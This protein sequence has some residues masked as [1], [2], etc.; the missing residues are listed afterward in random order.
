MS[1]VRKVAAQKAKHR[2]AAIRRMMVLDALRNWLIPL[3]LAAA[4]LLLWVVY[5][6]ELVGRGAAVTLAGALI[7]LGALYGALREFLDERTSART[8]LLVGGFGAA[9]FLAGFVL[10]FGIVNPPPP[11]FA[12]TVR[13]KA[14]AVVVPLHDAPGRYRLLV[15]G[16]FPPS[17]QGLQRKAHYRLDVEEAGEHRVLEGD[18]TDEWARRRVGRRGSAQVHV[19]HDVSQHRLTVAPGSD[20]A[21][22]LDEI[23]SDADASVRVEVYPNRFPL[24]A[25]AMFAVLMTIVALFLV[26]GRREAKGSAAATGATLAVIAAIGAMQAWANPHPSLGSLVG[27]AALGAA[28][29]LP[30]AALLWKAVGSYARRLAA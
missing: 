18:F 27:F 16:H 10:F 20:L 14:G 21:L 2:N 13:A 1:T 4:G 17:D 7:L 15:E 26:D 19:Q 6:I 9:F 11:V 23:S 3:P 8:A 12:S 30:V 5:Q 28:V 25:F 29:G 22:R 24:V